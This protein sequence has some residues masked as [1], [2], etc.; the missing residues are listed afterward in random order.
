MQQGDLPGARQDLEQAS[1]LD[2]KNAYVWAAL[3]EVYLRSGQQAL[4]AG[5]AKKAEENGRDN[6]IVCHALALYYADAKQPRT[7]AQLE[8]VFAAS[9]QA[10]PAA[11]TRAAQWYLESGDVE[12][13]LPLA[14]KSAARDR[15]MA[16]AWA[17]VLL[18]QE[19]F[20]AAAEL[21]NTSLE[22]FPND[23]QLKLALGVARY[24]Q[25][26]FEEAI[27]TFLSV[28]K[29]DSTIEQP[30][31]FI[32]RMLD[33]A[34]SHLTEIIGDC[35]AW[36]RAN[37]QNAR[38]QL[39]LAKALAAQD[40]GNSR[41]EALLRRSIEL[42]P[43]NWEAHYELGALLESRHQFAPAAEELRRAVVLNPK[44]PSPH[45]HLARVY[46]RLGDREKAAAERKLHQDL[47]APAN[48]GREF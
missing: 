5:A 8:A 22:S 3:A 18:R 6:P 43:S 1:H 14:K 39:E 37:P 44:D 32:G 16:F 21:V 2:G 10:D 31:L 35:E 45:Y 17:Q 36:A 27:Q 7:A 11:A 20:T 15:D 40:S 47:T 4:A 38:A 29:I 42:D 41:S 23:A 19:N 28:I 24:G 46:D 12:D 26:R 33:Q 13:G 9:A 30:Y 34:G 48:S 25:R